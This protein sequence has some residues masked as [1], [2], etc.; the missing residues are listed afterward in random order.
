MSLF[1]LCC[2][3]IIVLVKLA[4]EKLIEEIK[5]K[6]QQRKGHVFLFIWHTGITGNIFTIFLSEMTQQ[7]EQYSIYFFSGKT[8]KLHI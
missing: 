4:Y 8:K 2:F 3:L 1:L 6:Q 7:L 5:I